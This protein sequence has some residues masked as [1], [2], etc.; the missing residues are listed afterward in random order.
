MK[1][2]DVLE[3]YE[4]FVNRLTDRDLTWITERKQTRLLTFSFENCG[5]ELE[6]KLWLLV[7][8]VNAN[9]VIPH[10]NMFYSKP[11]TVGRPN[12]GIKQLQR[13]EEQEVI[14]IHAHP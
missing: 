7:H 12:A 13:K 6:Q 1:K 2:T 10:E 14:S 3:K 11:K 8:C 9:P 4:T 5:A